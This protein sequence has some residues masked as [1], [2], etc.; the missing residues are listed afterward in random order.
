LDQLECSWNPKSQIAKQM[1]WNWK[2]KLTVSVQKKVRPKL[3]ISG[4]LK[5]ALKSRVSY[6]ISVQPKLFI[7][8]SGQAADRPPIVRRQSAAHLQTVCGSCADR[9]RNDLL[10]RCNCRR[11]TGSS[12]FAVFL[13]FASL[14]KISYIIKCRYILY[15]DLSIIILSVWHGYG[16]TRGIT[17]MG[18]AGA[19]TVPVFFKTANTATRTRNVQKNR[20]CWDLNQGP[21]KNSKI[22]SKG[23]IQVD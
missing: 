14:K 5:W 19:G 18:A 21:Q 20:R 22:I 15:I 12:N 4:A 6:L 13:I 9:H 8:L 1:C 17:G 16:Y 23:K 2:P 7:S 3:N 11:P 10:R